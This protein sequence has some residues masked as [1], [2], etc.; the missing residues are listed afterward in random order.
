MDIGLPRGDDDQLYHAIVK[1]RAVD[2]EGKPIGRANNN[3]LTD[4]RRY[5]DEFAD[6][7]HEILAAN[8]IVEKIF[9]DEEGHRQMLLEEIIHHRKSDEA[10]QPSEAF[11]TTQS[12]R[13][14]H[15]FTQRMGTMCLMEGQIHSVCV[16]QRSHECIPH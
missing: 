10:L 15:K 2:V 4:S 7:T 12:G 6:G 11:Y 1:K 13:Q 14:K 3:P 9:A 16:T 8:V 5:E